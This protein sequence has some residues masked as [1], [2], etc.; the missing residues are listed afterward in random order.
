LNVIENQNSIIESNNIDIPYA[1]VI[2]EKDTLKNV[3]KINE[4]LEY[5][6][7]YTAGRFGAWN[8]FSMEDSFIDGEHASDKVVNRIKNLN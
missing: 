2:F 8:Y 1:Y 7:I 5:N 4:F 6:N 3:K